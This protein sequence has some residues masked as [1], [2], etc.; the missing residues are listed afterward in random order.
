VAI[1]NTLVEFAVGITRRV[2][3]HGGFAMWENPPSRAAGSDYA[4]DGREEHA[5]MW[6]LRV[7]IDMTASLSMCAVVF[8]QCMVDIDSPSPKKTQLLCTPNIFQFV[9]ASFAD[10]QCVHNNDHG[11]NL[12]G[13]NEEGEFNST[14]A[15]TFSPALNWLIVATILRALDLHVDTHLH[16]LTL[17][18][19]VH[20][21]ASAATRGLAGAP[22]GFPMPVIDCCGTV[23]HG[24]ADTPW[25]KS[26]SDELTLNLRAPQLQSQ[27]GFRSIGTASPLRVTLPCLYRVSRGASTFVQARVSND[28]ELLEV[29][30]T[31]TR[32][33]PNATRPTGGA[34]CSTAVT[35]IY[36]MGA[37]FTFC[38]VHVACELPCSAHGACY[39]G[40][41]LRCRAVF[42]PNTE[43]MLGPNL[44]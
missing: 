40:G 1:A 44:A 20:E 28:G 14:A 23:S 22:A 16:A 19:F 42:A 3:S 25:V 29:H 9:H 10:R 21:P 7:V 39:I 12:T 38:C 2:A 24:S 30:L 34:A 37:G 41:L 43:L 4:L 11:H 6:D 13:L 17:V 5:S 18:V 15:A 33:V 26:W 36:R 32:T 31:L 35:C 8:D 27:L